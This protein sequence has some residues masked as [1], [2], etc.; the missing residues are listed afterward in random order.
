TETS[1]EAKN[2]R[3]TDK[4][5]TSAVQDSDISE[6]S[7][8]SPE[9][10]TAESTSASSVTTTAENT[11][12]PAD[13]YYLSGIVYEVRD[14]SIIINETD[15]KKMNISVSDNSMIAD[16]NTGD[17]VE[18]TYNGLI[19]EGDI[20]YAYDPYSI[21]VTQKADKKYQLEKFEFNGM[22]FSMLVPENWSSKEIDYPQEGDFTDWGI[23]FT[24]DGASGSMDITW[25]SSITITGGFDK[26]P[27]T[28]NGISAK[29]YSSQG[30]W[31]FFVF[32]NNYVATDNFF[33]T[34]QYS[35][36]ADDMELMIN[37]IEFM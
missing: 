28:I 20:N 6:S 34:S 15:F 36:Y 19:N 17:R 33:G 24:P 5:G 1:A 14:K 27:L 30:V 31:R 13:V 8:I 21:E 37:T 2:P 22:A 10:S 16:I 26:I 9:N 29:E 18:I 23:R 25:H 4:T 3:T 12:K 11:T 32:D 35:D 7:Q